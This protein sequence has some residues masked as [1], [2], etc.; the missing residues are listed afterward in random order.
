MY[1]CLLIFAFF[2]VR[3]SF[4]AYL[5]TILFLSMVAGW[6]PCTFDW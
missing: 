3:S 1:E 6:R 2:I 4:I 5:V